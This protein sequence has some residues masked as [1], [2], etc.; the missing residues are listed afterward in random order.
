M[1]RGGLDAGPHVDDG[2]FHSAMSTPVG[3]CFQKHSAEMPVV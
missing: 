3:F 2:H 1:G